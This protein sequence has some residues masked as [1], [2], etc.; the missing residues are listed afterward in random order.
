MMTP[1]D[2][3]F[4]DDGLLRDGQSIR[5][6]MFLMDGSAP[7]DLAL[8]RPGTRTAMDADLR[9]A[10]AY[11]HYVTRMNDAWR[12]PP[13]AAPPARTTDAAEAGRDRYVA[14]LADAWRGGQRK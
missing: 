6:P 7:D 4:D 2:H 1:H 10:N 3:R 14:S 5:V 8:H 13:A 9:S 12:S 11:Q